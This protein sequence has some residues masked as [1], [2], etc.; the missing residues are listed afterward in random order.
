MPAGGIG[1]AFVERNGLMFPTA[2]SCLWPTPTRLLLLLRL[3]L[4]LNKG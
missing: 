4:R 3:R 1:G 2:P